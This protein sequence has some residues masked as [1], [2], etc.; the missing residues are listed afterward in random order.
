MPTVPPVTFSALVFSIVPL[1]LSSPEATVTL[2]VSSTLRVPSLVTV[3]LSSEAPLR[4]AI[5]RTASA[6][7]V[8]KDPASVSI[9][10]TLASALLM[11]LPAVAS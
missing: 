6:A 8:T 5:V 1:L 4:P 9:E 2:A 3:P 10:S 11:K 7:F